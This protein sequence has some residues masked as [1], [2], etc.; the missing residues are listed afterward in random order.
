MRWI[1]AFFVLILCVST[2]T[3]SAVAA[4][5]AP[6]CSNPRSAADT[7]FVYQRPE[8]WDL[9][10]A[11]ACL[12]VA[13][14]TDA[15]RTAVQLRQ[16]LD[17]RGIWVP[18][19]SIPDDPEYTEEGRHIHVPMPDEFPQMVMVRADD[20]RWLYSRDTVEAVPGLYTDTFSPLSQWFQ[21]QLPSVFYTRI[22]GVYGWQ[23][24]YAGLLVLV[25]WMVGQLV[26][27]LLRSQVIR[28]VK[29]VGITLDEKA[30][31][32]TNG[33][34]V[35]M[36]TVGVVYLGLADLQLPIK[37]SG[38]LH[39]VLWGMIWV[40][41]L[42]ALY[43]FIYVAEVIAGSW[44]ASTESKLDD[45]LIPLVRQAAQLGL[46]VVGGLYLVD[47]L[48]FDVW[49]L[50]AGVGIGGLAF[51]LAAQDTVANVFGSLNIFVDKPFQIGDA[52][53]VG[54]VDGVVEEVGFRSTRVRT[55]YNSLVTIPNSKI[56]N[57][58][59][60]NWGLRHQRRQRFILGLTYDS[61]PDQLEAFVA[62]V[63]AM[64]GSVEAVQE[65]YQV[66]I[67]D[68]GASSIDILVQY[69]LVVPGWDAELAM[70]AEHILNFM[71]LAEKNGVSFAFPSTSVYVE[72]MP[73]KSS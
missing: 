40:A 1:R 72:S 59:V 21:S 32:R 62:D 36:V 41:L 7:L 28:W 30:Y 27:L 24:L 23:V 29:R 71:R 35:A 46:I 44:T 60:D 39:F 55:Y 52:V 67:N 18:V 57:A 53:S 47:E 5:A 26:R 68:L 12:D 43:R 19:S 51:A 33:P 22:V 54:G 58:N 48:G 14:A 2:P 20:G 8:S 69:H 45:Q 17:A 64:L 13:S 10:K 9:K 61:T 73:A 65:G 66:R 3:S 4:P 42:V 56:T 63:H 31:A 70:R 6:D 25:A 50:A 37:L 49:K 38:G 15:E 11:G 16:V 34:I